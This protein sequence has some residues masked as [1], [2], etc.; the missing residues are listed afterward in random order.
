[1]V[2]MHDMPPQIIGKNKNNNTNSIPSLRLQALLNNQT[3]NNQHSSSDNLGGL[4]YLP[5]T[6]KATPDPS[7]HDIMN[8]DESLIKSA[9]K[10]IMAKKSTPKNTASIMPSN[11]QQQYIVSNTIHM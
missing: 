5:I 7:M 4:M 10:K 1:M 6:Q 2:E 3:F 8:R 11:S 9:K